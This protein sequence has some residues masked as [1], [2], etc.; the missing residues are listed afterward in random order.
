[1]ELD[2]FFSGTKVDKAFENAE[3]LIISKNI[4]SFVFYCAMCLWYLSS[5]TKDCTWAIS[6]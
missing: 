3:G 6:S 2:L 4:C 1:M 5:L